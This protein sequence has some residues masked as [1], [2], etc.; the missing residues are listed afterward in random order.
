MRNTILFTYFCLLL[1]YSGL[2]QAGVTRSCESSN[3]HI[4]G[5][6]RL[7]DGSIRENVI[8]PFHA[9]DPIMADGYHWLR[10]P[11]ARRAACH[12]ASREA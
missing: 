6:V 4:I 2:S 3:H 8:V 7:S 12:N 1:A 5:D 11:M 10:P 9:V